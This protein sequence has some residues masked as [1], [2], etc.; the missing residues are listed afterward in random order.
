MACSAD[1]V[2]AGTR[3][4]A[5]VSWLH[6]PARS[7]AAIFLQASMTRSVGI[8]KSAALGGRELLTRAAAPIAIE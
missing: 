8:I 2:Q 7:Y 1:S 5:R 3:V 6:L 4:D